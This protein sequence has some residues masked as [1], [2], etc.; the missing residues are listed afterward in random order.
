MPKDSKPEGWHFSFLLQR[1]A[2]CI[3]TKLIPNWFSIGPN[4]FPLCSSIKK[5]ASFHPLHNGVCLHWKE[6]KV[7][8]KKK[9]VPLHADGL[10]SLAA[11]TYRAMVK[12]SRAKGKK[13]LLDDADKHISTLTL[14]S[15][16]SPMAYILPQFLTS[17]VKRIASHYLKED[18]EDGEILK[19]INVTFLLFMFIICE[20]NAGTYTTD[21]N[22]ATNWLTHVN[23]LAFQDF[24]LLLRAHCRLVEENKIHFQI[25]NVC[26]FKNSPQPLCFKRK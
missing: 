16:V 5:T 24:F 1:P 3:L 15:R 20:S 11:V 7:W 17:A 19:C 4:E 18:S 10:V 23:V 6:S 9:E 22:L 26:V 14:T 12:T 21:C 13:A 25:E 2:C 8:A